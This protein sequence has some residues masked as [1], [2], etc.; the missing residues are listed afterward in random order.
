ML[1]CIASPSP[2]SLLVLVL[3]LPRWLSLHPLA[4]RA[5][6]EP[7]PLTFIRPDPATRVNDGAFRS[8]PAAGV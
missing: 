2:L 3:I 8:A 7:Q 6:L 4:Q 1:A 5:A